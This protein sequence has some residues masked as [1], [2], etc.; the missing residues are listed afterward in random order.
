MV[1]RLKS[2][3]LCSFL[4]LG[5]DPLGSVRSKPKILVPLRSALNGLRSPDAIGQQGRDVTNQL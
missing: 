4:P 1:Q 2:G 3:P 5:I